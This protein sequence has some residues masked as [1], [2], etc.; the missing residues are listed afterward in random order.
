MTFPSWRV[1][2]TLIVA[3]M[4]GGCAAPATRTDYSALKTEN[5]R[6]ILIVP[7][8]NRSV[9]V[10]A[11]DYLLATVSRPLAEKGY[12]V[13]PVRLVKSVMDDDGLSDADLVHANSPKR[14][15]QLFGA[16]AILYITIEKWHA[17]YAIFSTAVVVELSYILKSAATEQ[18][19]WK[20]QQKVVYQPQNNSNGLAGLIANAIVAAITRAAPNYMPLAQQANRQA[21]YTKGT[22][23]PAGPYSGLYRKDQ[24]DF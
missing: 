6:S 13:F 10:N 20:N 2:A 23:L 7:A 21:I 19:L 18:V 9:E 3:C 22:G 4:L 12:Y 11:A 16:D 24:E 8:I 5:P 1:R 17:Q 15:G 14:L